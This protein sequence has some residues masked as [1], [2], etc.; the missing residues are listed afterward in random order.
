[1][2]RRRV[3]SIVLRHCQRDEQGD[4]QQNHERHEP[5]W[6]RCTAFG[7][8]TIVSD[9]GRPSPVTTGLYLVIRG[10]GRIGCVIVYRSRTLAWPLGGSTSRTSP[11]AGHSRAPARTARPGPGSLAA[12]TRTAAEP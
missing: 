3:S 1:I 8:T 5:D 2:G 7:R 9:H 4:A 6:A 12:P 11:A 10:E